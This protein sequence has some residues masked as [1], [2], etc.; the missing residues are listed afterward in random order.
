[1]NQN[2]GSQES[3]RGPLRREHWASRLGFIMAAAGSAVGL[4]NVW[5]FPYVAGENGGGAF[6]VV[7]LAL[8][9]SLG[10]SI[11][12]AE[13]AIGRAAQRNPVGACR[14]LG[15]RRW[16]LLG[17]LGLVAGFLILSF[18]VVVAG[19][20]LTY[21]LKFATGGL[22]ASA[23][24][25]AQTFAA[26]VADPRQTIPAAAVFMILT[27]VIV[28]GGVKG[29]IERANLVLMP[30]LFVILVALAI[31]A[32]TLPGAAAGL[33]FYLAPDF[34]KLGIDTLTRALGQ[35]FFSL[36]IG[37]GAMITYGSYLDRGQNIPSAAGW[38]V[39]LDTL[40][41][42]LAGFAVLPAVFAAGLDP[43]AGPGLAFVVLPT[44]FANMPL[45]ALFGTLF[46]V[47]LAIA[48]LTSSISLLEPLVAYFID[49]HGLH[50]GRITVLIALAAFVLSVPSALSLGPWSEYTLFGKSLL[51]LLDALTAGIMLPAGGLL[52]A[53]FVGWVIGPRAIAELGIARPENSTLAKVWLWI[54][55]LP[56]PVAI[57]WILLTWAAG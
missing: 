21:A 29:G 26:F 9:F 51:D 5:R 6:L 16:A 46:F 17:Y 47:L 25:P 3:L 31:R 7:Y 35:A 41:A 1:M 53:I 15:G 27:V 28:L 13:F 38:V 36:S 43:E 39:G 23:G 4:G 45:G 37:L 54:L 10:L 22:S 19:W 32:V 30:L 42:I 14:S 56:A 40:V 11:M 50:R 24:E 2:N 57:A 20:T 49:E 18:Y 48:A 12:I 55:R 34:S 33:S 44:V 8:V 52:I